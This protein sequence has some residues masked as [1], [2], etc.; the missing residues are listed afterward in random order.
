MPSSC[1][2]N[3]R[4][5]CGRSKTGR[6]TRITCTCAACAGQRA[7][8]HGHLSP[9]RPV[10]G[11]MGHQRRGGGACCMRSITRRRLFITVHRCRHKKFTVFFIRLLHGSRSRWATGTREPGSSTATSAEWTVSSSTTRRS[12]RRFRSLLLLRKA[13]VHQRS[14][15]SAR[16]LCWFQVWG[17]TGEKIYGPDT[18]ID[19]RDNQMRFSLLCQVTD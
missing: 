5:P 10:Q 13:N 15:V 18:G 14:L 1:S 16:F 6:G 3:S 9:L 17:K 8:R 12:W 7:P 11:R 19:Y 2:G 4:Q